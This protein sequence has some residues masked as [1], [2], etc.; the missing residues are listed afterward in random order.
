MDE[1]PN[2]IAEL[3]RCIEEAFA[4]I[5]YPGDDHI[6]EHPDHC[7]ECR[8]TDDFFA[9]RHWHDLAVADRLPTGY[10]GLSFLTPRAWRFF[11]PAYL[12]MGLGDGEWAG[13]AADTAMFHLAP[14][15]DPGLQDYFR[16]RAEG[17]SAAQRACLA[18]VTAWFYEQDPDRLPYLEAAAYW[19]EQAE[20]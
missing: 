11:L 18:A 14:P 2:R 12:L 5:P 15:Q 9:G 6:A 20:R 19:E 4:G 10:G 1:R 16:E 7:P 13:D 3:R 8:F 17:F